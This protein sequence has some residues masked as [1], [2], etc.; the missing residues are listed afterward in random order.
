MNAAF[1]QLQRHERG[2]HV[3]RFP[4]SAWTGMGEFSTAVNRLATDFDRRAIE[5]QP[6]DYVKAVLYSAFLIFHPNGTQNQYLFPA[7]VPASLQAIAARNDENY[8]DGTSARYVVAS[9]PVLCP[10]AALGI[11]EIADRFRAGPRTA[12]QDLTP[13][14]RAR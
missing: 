2:I 6:L 14:E 4:L 1:M 13:A 8:Q 7:G 9:V 12:P 10:A 3:V 5:A 11:E